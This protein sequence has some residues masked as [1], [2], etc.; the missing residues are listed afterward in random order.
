MLVGCVFVLLFGCGE[1]GAGGESAAAPGGALERLSLAEADAERLA[2]DAIGHRE[3]YRIVSAVGRQFTALE[4]EEREAV[5]IAIGDWGREFVESDVFAEGYAELRATSKPSEPVFETSVEDEVAAQIEQQR[6][7]LEQTRKDIVAMMPEADR[8]SL[9]ESLDASEASFDD[10]ALIEMQEQGLAMVREAEQQQYEV[11][12]ARWEEAFPEEPHALVARRLEEFL[13]VCAD[14]DFDADLV[15]AYGLMRF[16]DEDYEQ[17]P[18]EW[19]LCFRA[20]EPSVAAARE[21]AA[22][23]LA[24]FD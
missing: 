7:Q 21:I 23:W 18:A 17:K 1:S 2:I 8:E 9:L 11:A 20:G 4:D 22:D 13:A 5:V 24:A 16:E 10:P 12:L 6:E 19:K 3:T 15:E 14:V